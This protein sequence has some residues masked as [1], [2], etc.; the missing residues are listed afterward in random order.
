MD[1]LFI[2]EYYL[3]LFQIQNSNQE[4]L[5][6]IYSILTLYIWTRLPEYKVLFVCVYINGQV[7]CTGF[8]FKGVQ[9]LWNNFFFEIRKKKL[10]TKETKILY[11]I[12]Q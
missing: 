5:S 6:N 10:S 3:Y 1:I 7:F 11:H 4:V 8:F 12:A 9:D 2:F